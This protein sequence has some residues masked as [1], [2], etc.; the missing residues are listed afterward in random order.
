[1][2]A[3]QGILTLAPVPVT[4]FSAPVAGYLVTL[5]E[6]GGATAPASP[7]AVALGDV[8]FAVSLEAGT[9]TAS[10]QPVDTSG[11]AL[12]A[13]VV[14]APLVL[15]APATVLVPVGIFLAVAS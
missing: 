14:S 15:A 9:W 5:S 1:M 7:I 3:V 13:A 12:A 11:N 6:A 8:G 2:T 10:V 4:Q